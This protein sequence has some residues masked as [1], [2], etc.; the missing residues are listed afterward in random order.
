VYWLSVVGPF[1]PWSLFNYLAKN[2][3]SFF[4]LTNSMEDFTSDV[5]QYIKI[6]LFM[7][8]FEGWHSWFFEG[9]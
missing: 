4:S 6:Y 7:R 1:Q 3:M 5:I 9:Q 2:N 8:R